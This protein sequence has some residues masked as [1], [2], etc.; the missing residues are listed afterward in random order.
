MKA[1]NLTTLVLTIIAGLDVGIVGLTNTD[2]ISSLLGVATPLARGVEMILG[3]SALYQLYPL[4]KA[5]TVGE[6]HA[7]SSHA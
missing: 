1:L 6:I 5:W 7:E 4:A 2:V 3:L